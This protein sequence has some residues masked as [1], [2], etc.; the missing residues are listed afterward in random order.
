MRRSNRLLI[1]LL[2]GL[3]T[4]CHALPTEPVL[5]IPSAT[6]QIQSSI[7][8][9]VP[10]T[11]TIALP[12]ALFTAPTRAAFAVGSQPRTVAAAN[13]NGDQWPDAVVANAGDGTLTVLF[14]LG[15]GQFAETSLALAAGQQPSDIEV[16]DLDRDGDVDL[17]V[18]NHETSQITVLLN[19]GEAQFVPAPG[20]P[21]DT[22]ARPHVHGLA[23]GD[24][25]GDDWPDVAVESADTRAVRI[26]L[27]G[28]QGLAAAISIAVDTMPYYRI[29]AAD[30][31]GDGLP[32]VLIPGHSNNT[33]RIIQREGKTLA[34]APWTISLA[35]Q[36][37][38]VVGDDVNGDARNDIIVVHSDAV[39][40]WLA[41]STGYVLAAG[42]PFVIQGATEV[43]TGD[44]DGDG[45][46]E[47]AVGPWDGQEVV[48]LRGK[49]LTQQ[50]VR[51][52]EQL[53]G[54][55]IA[56]LNGDSRG[57]L[58]VA[59]PHENRLVVLQWSRDS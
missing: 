52:C 2:I 22:G 14:G 51:T 9:T 41:A 31:T 27:G 57:E 26:L 25:N 23:T 58:L 21:F 15:T 29:G 35:E 34:L 50:A 11:A 42:S 59:C 30:M 47:T 45:I 43:A 6:P 44:I 28:P 7:S 5:T 53:I 13:L 55:A 32:D 38:M 12:T 18:A 39:S 40:L 24:F 46:A 16:I 36:P 4:A 49:T 56:D 20:S 33:I 17:V 1:L 3:S 48:I 54:L 37:W 8:A 10:A 19:T